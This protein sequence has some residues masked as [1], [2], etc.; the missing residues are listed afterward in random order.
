LFVS[1]Y[2]SYTAKLTFVSVMLV[3]FWV[4]LGLTCTEN[5]YSNFLHFLNANEITG[6]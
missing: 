6:T 4:G 1:S 3:S 2:C 5:L